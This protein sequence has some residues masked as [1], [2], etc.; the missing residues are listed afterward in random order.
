V[1]EIIKRLEAVTPEQIQEVARTCFTSAGIALGAL[2]N[3]NG[4]R[5]DRSRLEI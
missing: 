3:L 1:E 4:F 5:V 2:G